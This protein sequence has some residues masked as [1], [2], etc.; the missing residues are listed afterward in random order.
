MSTRWQQH[1][2][3]SATGLVLILFFYFLQYCVKYLVGLSPG[4]FLDHCGVEGREREGGEGGTDCRGA[5]MTSPWSCAVCGGGLP[6]AM[7]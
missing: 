5:Q 6:T 7:G 1:K 4:Q 2:T 3:K